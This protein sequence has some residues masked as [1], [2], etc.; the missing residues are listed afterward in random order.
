MS[1]NTPNLSQLFGQAQAE[2]LL[3]P[4]SANILQVHDVGQQIQAAL[5]AP[6][7]DVASSEVT[8][9][10]LLVDDSGS[11]RFAG[12]ADAV[13][14][15]HNGVLEALGSSKQKESIF[16]H[17]RYL[18]GTVLYPFLQLAQSVQMDSRNYNP[19]GGTPLYDQSIV[20]LGTLVAEVQRFADMGVPARGVCLIIT[21]GNDEGSFKHNSGHVKQLVDDLLRTERH[22]IAAMGVDDGHTDFG[23]VFTGMGIRREWILTPKN[24]AKDIRAAF[25]LFSQS[26]V[27]ASQNAAAFSK[28]ALGGFG[29]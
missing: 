24:T 29:N 14:Q 21:D 12:N 20:F 3:S 26:A 22:I 5:G 19:N 17:C 11:I 1:E 4:G 9:V 18:N 6:V 13:R 27:R 2:G 25:N 28:T 10:G 15:G 8:L 16:A 23:L 7:E